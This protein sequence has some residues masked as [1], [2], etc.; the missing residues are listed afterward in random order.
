MR[1]RG[2]NQRQRPLLELPLVQV[3]QFLRAA[4]I[5]GLAAFLKLNVIAESVFEPA[6]D[7]IDGE[8][9]DINANPLPT[10]LLRR[11]NRRAATAKRIKHDVALVAAGFNDAF[12]QHL[13]FLRWITETLSRLR[14][15]RIYIGDNIADRNTSLSL[16]VAFETGNTSFC[17]PIDQTLFIKCVQLLLHRPRGALFS[18]QVQKDFIWHRPV[19]ACFSRIELRHARPDSPVLVPAPVRSPTRKRPFSSE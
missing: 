7:E 18:K 6:F 13:W 5:R 12:Q 2:V 14:A 16:K 15:D 19:A 17:R 8:V 9:S 11:V 3:R 10:E 4:E 1:G